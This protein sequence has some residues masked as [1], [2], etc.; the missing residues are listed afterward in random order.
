MKI[1]FVGDQA[2]LKKHNQQ[3]KPLQQSNPVT[4]QT[5]CQKPKSIQFHHNQ[6]QSF[7]HSHTNTDGQPS[8]VQ[9]NNRPSK[10]VG[11]QKADTSKSPPLRLKPVK[12]NNFVN[13]SNHEDREDFED[14]Q[15]DQ[16]HHQLHNLNKGANKYHANMGVTSS[17]QAPQVSERLITDESTGTRLTGSPRSKNI[18]KLIK[19]IRLSFREQGH[20]P[21]TTIDFYRIGKVLGKGAFGKVNLAVHKLTECLCAVKSINKQYFSDESQSKKVMQ[22]VVMLKRTKHKN[23]VRLYEYFETE[24]HLLFVI[25]LC[26]GGDLL[27]YVRRRRRLKEDVAKCLFKQLIEA[28]AYCHRKSILHRDIKLDN[29][30]L[31]ADG[32][33]KLCD[34]GVGKI[35]KKGEKMT[36]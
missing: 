14:S 13:D 30:L 28:L 16:T 25:E 17:L 1:T 4:N 9:S 20:A 23:I 7:L 32:Q 3:N 26:A 31:D 18:R 27:N 33:V 10:K 35:V 34:F 11:S 5:S 8:P 36:E 22:E 12:R 2:L 6:S 19:L 24:K 29:I 15:L 21:Q